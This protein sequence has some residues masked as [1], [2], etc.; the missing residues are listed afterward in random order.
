MSGASGAIVAKIRSMYGKRL[1]ARD[2]DEM[3]EQDSVS[4]VARYLAAS[5]SYSEA[6]RSLGDGDVH[7][8]ALEDAVRRARF[9]EFERL[10]K[11]EITVGGRLAD[12]IIST[13][14]VET[15]LRALYAITP[16]VA[17]P[18]DKGS[19]SGSEYIDRHLSFSVEDVL[20]ARTVGEIAEAVGSSRYRKILD[21]FPEGAGP[22]D[23]IRAEAAL[24]AEFYTGAVALF[25]DEKAGSACPEI[26]GM[27]KDRID[28]ENVAAAYRLKKFFT[29][30]RDDVLAA[31]IPGGGMRTATAEAIADADG[32]EGVLTAARSDREM[33]KLLL[34]LDRCRTV[35]EAPARR[36][37]SESCRLIRYSSSSAAVTASYYNV[38]AVECDNIIKIIEGKR[39]GISPGAI[40]EMLI[41]D[42]RG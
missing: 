27:L 32:A 22:V 37:F 12:Y 31:M 16:G 14:E 41:T 10:L 9:S 20:S 36:I 33:K 21:G 40:R 24:R 8:R 11:F 34:I 13:V 5:P 3:T 18:P 1:T 26:A 29:P 28:L 4:S 42:E 19:F 23:F 17:D 30:S 15:I 38:V 35:D 6:M 2:W 7:R 39:Y 25:E